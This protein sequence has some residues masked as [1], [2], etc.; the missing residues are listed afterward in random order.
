MYFCLLTRN[1]IIMNVNDILTNL[2]TKH[3]GEKEYLQAVNLTQ[4]Q[5]RLKLLVTE[6]LLL[7]F[8]MMY[9]LKA[10]KVLLI[11]CCRKAL[12]AIKWI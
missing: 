12:K 8:L 4:E 3:P 2:E 9:L 10:K 7:V 6:L 5:V 1:T 11:S